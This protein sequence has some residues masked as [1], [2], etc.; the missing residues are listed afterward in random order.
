MH[1]SW[2]KPVI[3]TAAII[4][5]AVEAQAQRVVSPETMP[6]TT[7]CC[8]ISAIDHQSGILS[9]QS[10]SKIGIV[11]FRIG[12]YTQPT[13]PAGDPYGPLDFA[14]LTIASNFQPTNEPRVLKELH[15]GEAVWV[16]HGGRVSLTGRDPCCGVIGKSLGGRSY[17]SDSLNR[18]A[19]CARVAKTSYPDGGHD[20]FPKGLLISSGKSPDGSDATYS[21]TCTCS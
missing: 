21:W 7:P 20:C 4:A 9:A 19:E 10:T 1:F 14:A 5:C 3:T 2:V 13:N 12:T 15:V 8:Y 17:S 6:I 18:V 16:S 11:K